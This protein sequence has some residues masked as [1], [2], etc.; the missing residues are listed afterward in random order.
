MS[1]SSFLSLYSASLFRKRQDLI[2]VHVYSRNSWSLPRS[3]RRVVPH[4]RARLA[5]RFV[6]SL[7]LK[8]TRRRRSTP[9]AWRSIFSRRESQPSRPRRRRISAALDFLSF[10]FLD[11]HLSR[12]YSFPTIQ[13]RIIKTNNCTLPYYSSKSF[14]SHRNT[15]FVLHHPDR[16]SIHVVVFSKS[17]A[18]DA[19]VSRLTRKRAKSS[20]DRR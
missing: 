12:Y 5:I 15:T 1:S 14:R 10:V 19:A 13:N 7:R 3:S 2:P 17:R 6:V 11:Y 18:L 20:T 4:S 9:Q 16:R 8:G